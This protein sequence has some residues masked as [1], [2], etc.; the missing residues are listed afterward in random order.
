MDQP[1]EGRAPCTGQAC[2][3]CLV[4]RYCQGS[5][6]CCVRLERILRLGTVLGLSEPRERQ[7]VVTMEKVLTDQD[8]NRINRANRMTRVTGVFRN[9]SSVVRAVERL[10]RK[11]VPADAIRVFVHGLQGERREVPVDDE[12]GTLRGAVM[13]ALA[14]ALVGLVLVFAGFSELFG[15][16]DMDVFSFQGLSVAIRAMVSGAA[17]AVPLGA[18][19][20]MGY[21][22][23]RKGVSALDFETGTAT[24][25][26]ES[27]E[28]AE[29][30]RL[31]LHEAG[32]LMVAVD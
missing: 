17:A 24:V 9:R 8:T 21:W 27:D 1:P 2:L 25:V 10:S 3:D 13:G 14:G 32:A 5:S 7:A 22:Q 19:L 30:S 12:S 15:P 28:L 18:L 31:T 6:P 26:V 4:S 20:G 23:G 11:S 29:L 16:A